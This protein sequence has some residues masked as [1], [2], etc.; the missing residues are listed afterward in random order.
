MWISKSL[1]PTLVKVI[2]IKQQMMMSEKRGRGGK[3]AHIP[4]R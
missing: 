3:E 2:I 4:R 1:L